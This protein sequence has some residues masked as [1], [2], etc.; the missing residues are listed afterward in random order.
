MGEIAI[1][2]H[3]SGMVR[4]MVSLFLWFRVPSQTLLD[5]T[6]NQSIESQVNAERPIVKLKNNLRVLCASV[7][8]FTSA[9]P[10]FD[11]ILLFS[12]RILYE[13]HA[14]TR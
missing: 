12:Y 4:S 13:D 7:V 8:K 1:A 9:L 3:R 5:G 2:S 14:D 11:R 10:Q 6:P